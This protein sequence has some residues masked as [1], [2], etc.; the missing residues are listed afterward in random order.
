MACSP[1]IYQLIKESK[2]IQMRAKMVL[3]NV[4]KYPADGE[5]TQ[6]TLSFN[7]VSKSTAYPADGSDEDNTFAKF[8]PS[9][10]LSLTVCNPALLG[11]FKVGQK[12]YVDFSEVDSEPK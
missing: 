10:S 1:E 9:A 4:N 5:A 2:M 3:N 8:S 11:K 7:A 12:F 6:E